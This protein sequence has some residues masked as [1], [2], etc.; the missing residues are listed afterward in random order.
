MSKT[1][2]FFGAFLPSKVEKNP[3]LATD[4]NAIFH[5]D[6]DGAG[7]WTLDLKGGNSVS[8]GL[9]GDADCVLTT[10]SAS[11]EQ[12][13]DNPGKAVS[14]VMMGKLKISNLSHATKLQKILAG[15]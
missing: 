9:N 2:E 12:I 4:I 8:E 11:W 10:D 3:D 1:N 13:L 5:F 15:A 7:Q 14:M 6:I